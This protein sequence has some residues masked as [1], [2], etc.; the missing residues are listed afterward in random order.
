MPVSSYEPAAV[1]EISKL[2]N[3]SALSAICLAS[4]EPLGAISL[5]H[6]PKPA[7]Q[8][9]M[10]ITQFISLP[11]FQADLPPISLSS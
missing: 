7:M 5:L 3:Y 4:E 11:K 9:T 6:W 2:I 8:D 1:V 10:P